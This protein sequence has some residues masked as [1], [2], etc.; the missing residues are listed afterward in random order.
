M[1]ASYG[2]YI[3]SV[4]REVIMA[5]SLISVLVW[6]IITLSNL[7]MKVGRPWVTHLTPILQL[8]RLHGDVD[9]ILCQ[10]DFTP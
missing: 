5:Q 9:L 8:R 1:I 7:I 2:L 3:S 4:H 10:T 6:S